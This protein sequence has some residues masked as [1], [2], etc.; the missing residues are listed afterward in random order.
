MINWY[1]FFVSRELMT[2]TVRLVCGAARAKT[3]SSSVT[4]IC[5]EDVL[6][7]K[8]K[9]SERL[10]V[11]RCLFKQ[12]N[13]SMSR[14]SVNLLWYS[15]QNDGIVAVLFGFGKKVFSPSSKFDW[16]FVE[17]G[18]FFLFLSIE[19]QISRLNHSGEID[20]RNRLDFVG[21]FSLLQLITVRH[22]LGH[23]LCRRR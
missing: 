23:D 5:L 16:F 15:C 6:T 13:S 3:I 22:T 14:T 19:S 9:A 2:L 17:F 10:R 18:G 11:F 12:R 20:E 4:E 8:L 1:I 7:D 21:F